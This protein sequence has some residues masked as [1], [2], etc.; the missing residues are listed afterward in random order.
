MPRAGILV[1]MIKAVYHV[2][3]SRTGLRRNRNETVR[4]II[5][6]LIMAVL[7]C[8]LS[9]CILPEEEPMEE[10]T[11]DTSVE[12]N[13]SGE[14]TTE[15]ETKPAKKKS[16]KD[17]SG[18]EKS[19]KT[20]P[21]KP[22]YGDQIDTREELFDYVQYC[23][24][25]GK[26]EI[27]FEMTDLDESDLKNINK[28]MEGFYGH[29]TKYS[30]REKIL[31]E[32]RQVTMTCQISDN[33]YVEQEMIWGKKIPESRKKAA[34]LARTC[35][36]VLDE[37][38]LDGK[39]VY[40]KEKAF[41]DYLVRNVVYDS[42]ARMK[43]AEGG[44]VYTA[45][46]ALVEGSAVCNGYAEAM[47][48]LCDLSGVECRMISGT[49]DGENHAWNLV[50]ID[51]EW[52]HV[53]VTWDDPVPDGGDR[54]MYDYLNLSDKEMKADHKWEERLYP[55]ADSMEYYYFKLNDA[56]CNDYQEFVSV[57]VALLS[58]RPDVMMVAVRNYSEDEYS[59]DALQFIFRESGARSYRYYMC[60]PVE[61]REL[62]FEL[63]Y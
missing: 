24:A 13:V 35:Q 56:L 14:A 37:L 20:K 45:Y 46:G 12:E 4:R 58:D 59:E 6:I 63:E 3:Y 34:R 52:Y 54:V 60:G 1:T 26:E 39:T 23:L 21:V 30:I 5:H 18:K 53:D 48:L 51:G 10:T 47:K 9:G 57:S 62:Y 8:S 36:D 28:N 61:R 11:V 49:V 2:K 38:D 41:H 19:A 17:K 7:I 55:E 40:R 42:K 16:S 27:T 31:D 44:D 50:S 25:K 32:S 43:K 33:Y 22:D 15:S 29:V